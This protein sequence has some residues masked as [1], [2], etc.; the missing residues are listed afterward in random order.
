MI[1]KTA[2]LALF[3]FS[4]LLQTHAAPPP[5]TSSYMPVVDKESFQTVLERMSNAKQGINDKQQTLLNQRYDLSNKPS[6]DTMTTGKPMQEGVRVKLPA[7]ITWDD[8][9]KMTPEQIK[10]KGVFPQGFLPLPHPNH[11]EGGMLFPKFAIDEINK[12]EGRDLTRFDLDFDIPDHFLPPFPA[13]IYLTTRPDLGDV[14]QGKLVTIENFYELFNGI[15]NPKQLEGLR[16]L[17]TPFPQQQFNQTA[18][19]RTVKPS[20]G[21]A[22]FDCH[23]N[24]HTNE[25]THLV[26]DI[27][28]Q[29]FR[30][31]ITTPSLRGVNIQR[32]FGSQRALKTVEDFTEFEQRAAYFDGDPVIATK[33]GVNVLER[34]SQVHFM[35]EF[36]EILD[37]PPAPKLKWDGKLDPAKA[38][39]AE[40]RGQELFFGKAQCATCHTP[41]YYTD[42]TMHN[43]QTERFFNPVLINGLKAVGDG[44]IKTFPLRG[45]KDS[46]PYL[47]DGRLLTLEDT[48]EFFNLVLSLQLNQQEKQDLTAFMK[49]L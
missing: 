29:E 10:E 34:G 17:V 49:A 42:N 25:A 33:K 8:L 12:Q 44:P 39:P 16:L 31:R 22:C 1:K 37:F 35:A 48:V 38:T 27:R 40:L 21:V 46:P 47:H 26:G 24:G 6:K 28:P 11:T 2:W 20:R 36:Q 7:G 3:S 5:P 30:H 13:P 18:D 45:I 23:A 15:L 19:R 4:Y 43:L 41:P 14:S 32:L 9:A